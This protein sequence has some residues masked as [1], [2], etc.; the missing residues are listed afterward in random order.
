MSAGVENTVVVR[1][2]TQ[3]EQ[4]MNPFRLAHSEINVEG[5]QS[6]S[7]EISTLLKT[8]QRIL[9]I[10]P[11]QATNFLRQASDLLEN[12]GPEA[13]LLDV[14]RPQLV[15][16]GLAPWQ[17]RNVIAHVEVNLTAAI[18]VED[19][20]GLCRLS[21]SHFSRAFKV[22][23]GEAPYAYII[24]RRVELA[25]T[26]ML[27]T[28]EPLSQ[29]AVFCGLADQAHLSNLFRRCVGTTPF[30][31]RRRNRNAGQPIFAR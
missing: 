18:R 20:A 21:V 24:S 25:Q 14:A 29:I 1:I 28:E 12:V 17:Y 11:D 6:R 10:D 8:A 2:P 30:E 3:V 26:L 9:D 13:E 15:Q 5:L 27:T 31:W 23:F 16:G 22:S 4:V 7:K 19:L